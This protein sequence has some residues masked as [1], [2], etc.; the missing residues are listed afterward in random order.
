MFMFVWRS[1]ALKNYQ[2][3]YIIACAETAAEA[4]GNILMTIQM[5]L[6]YETLAEDVCHLMFHYET[7]EDCLKAITQDIIDKPDNVTQCMFITGG[8]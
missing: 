8:E 7:K 2:S 3:G 6:E 5:K 4:R 1:E